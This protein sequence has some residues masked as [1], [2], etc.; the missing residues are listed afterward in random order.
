MKTIKEHDL[1]KAVF[2]NQKGE[3]LLAFWE[4]VYGERLSYEVGNT[5]EQTAFNEGERAFLLSINQLLEMK[6]E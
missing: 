3:Q 6:N 2:A 1:I 5:P 4:K